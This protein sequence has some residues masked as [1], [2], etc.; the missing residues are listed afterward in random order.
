VYK[1]HV[2]LL[3]PYTNPE[4]PNTEVYRF[5]RESMVRMLAKGKTLTMY[6][7]GPQYTKSLERSYT[8]PV[9]SLTCT[10]QSNTETKT[11]SCSPASD[12]ISAT[13]AE[14]L[15]EDSGPSPGD[16]HLLS[17]AGERIAGPQPKVPP[18]CGTS[19]AL[20]TILQ[21]VIVQRS[22]NSIRGLESMKSVAG[23]MA[24]AFNPPNIRQPLDR[25]WRDLKGVTAVVIASI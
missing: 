1:I 6:E 7:A 21:G 18:D 14:F 3:E 25:F 2:G 9:S 15:V 13:S 17:A 8:D 12:T 20:T 23:H 5:E 10:T 19:T 24:L 4:T 16:F 22:E 11:R